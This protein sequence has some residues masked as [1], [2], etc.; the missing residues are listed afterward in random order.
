MKRLLALFMLLLVS[1]WSLGGASADTGPLA[2]IPNST[3]AVVSTSANLYTLWLSN[4]TGGAVTVTIADRGTG[5]NG[6]PCQIWPVISIAA[7]TVYVTPMYGIP[8]LNGFTWTASSAN[9]VMG[10][11]AY[12]TK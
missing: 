7:N 12:F 6:S 4:T 5:C 9:S 1:A 8:A 11:I 3:T 2:Y 10:W